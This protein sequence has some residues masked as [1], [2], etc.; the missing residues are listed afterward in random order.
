MWAKVWDS[1]QLFS[2]SGINNDNENNYKVFFRIILF[3]TLKT[4]FLSFEIQLNQI[5]FQC[6]WCDIEILKYAFYED[7]F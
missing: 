5:Y 1:F 4:I 6:T 3:K 7:F 2:C